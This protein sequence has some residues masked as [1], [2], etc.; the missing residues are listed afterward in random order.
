MGKIA[1]YIKHGIEVRYYVLSGLSDYYKSLGHEVCLLLPKE[2][3]TDIKK[4]AH[5]YQIKTYTISTSV[6]NSN[7]YSTYLP[8]IRAI[9]DARRRAKN[10]EMFNHHAVVNTKRKKI[11]TI[12]KWHFAQV[13]I[14]AVLRKIIALL[15]YNAALK[16]AIQDIGIT[17]LYLGQYN[18][19]TQVLLG[20][21]ANKLGIKPH[22]T[23]NGLKVVFIDDFVPFK[24]TSLYTWNNIQTTLY[25]KANTRLP[26]QVFKPYGNLYHLFLRNTETNLQNDVIEKY[27][28]DLSKPLILY[29]LMFENIY[30]E[31]YKLLNTLIEN[32]DNTLGAQHYQLLIRRNPFEESKSHL[33]NI[34]ASNHVKIMDAYAT[35][36]KEDDWITI[37]PYGEKEWR[38]VL[39]LADLMITCPSLAVIDAAVCNTPSLIVT[40]NHDDAPNDKIGMLKESSF[41]QSL[42]QSPYIN[43]ADDINIFKTQAKHMLTIKKNTNQQVIFDS[44]GLAKSTIEKYKI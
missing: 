8:Y 13:L 34:Q 4:Y 6:F 27:Q 2:I 39:Q 24:I 1:F 17:E 21:N 10:A 28:L 31:E 40:F 29:A 14:E 42:I 5:E 43:I 26:K 41:L 12:F 15:F 35:K 3:T 44:L 36:I 19:I 32:L 20:V 18:S 22:V 11:D 9:T 38:E 23:S 7:K 25:Q 16:K 37:T 33:Q 30:P